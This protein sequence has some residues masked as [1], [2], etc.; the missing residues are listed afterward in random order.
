MAK[1]II[2]LS[3]SSDG[4]FVQVEF[5]KQNKIKD[6]TEAE[7]LAQA[8]IMSINDSNDFHAQNN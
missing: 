2:T 7:Q 4:V 8:I 3:D 1:V 6:P 5:E